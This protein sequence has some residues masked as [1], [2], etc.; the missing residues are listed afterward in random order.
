MIIKIN[1]DLIKRFKRFIR[2]DTQSSELPLDFGMLLASKYDINNSS[3]F[4]ERI[5]LEDD[6]KKNSDY[7]VLIKPNYFKFSKKVEHL[8]SSRAIIWKIHNNY[9]S[10]QSFKHF[11]E[12][13]GVNFSQKEY[14]FSLDKLNKSF[15]D[16]STYLSIEPSSLESINLTY[17]SKRKLNDTLS[18]KYY[19]YLS[20]FEQKEII[21]V[22][23]DELKKLN[24]PL[25][26]DGIMYSLKVNENLGGVLY[27]YSLASLGDSKDKVIIKRIEFKGKRRDF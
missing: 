7:F 16:Y 9:F 8:E 14:Y 10:L 15:S 12:K 22:S 25:K 18:K 6:L 21:I 1:T 23:A 5:K 20:S 11:I 13:N 3:L 2:E 4:N 26:K 27:S 17:F 24:V 19:S